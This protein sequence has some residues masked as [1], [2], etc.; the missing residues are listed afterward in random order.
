MTVRN[1]NGRN[2]QDLAG[3][4]LH[5]ENGLQLV[6]DPHPAPKCRQLCVGFGREA[7]PPSFMRLNTGPKRAELDAALAGDGGWALR[8]LDRRCAPI[9]A[10]RPRLPLVGKM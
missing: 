3:S 10:S 2:F 7:P 4:K 5:A 1:L 9:G 6:G 8:G